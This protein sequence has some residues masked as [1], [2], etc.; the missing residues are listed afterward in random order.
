MDARS[1]ISGLPVF[2]VRRVLELALVPGRLDSV[3]LSAAQR[4][5][6]VL[7]DII[8][9]HVKPKK[10][11]TEKN[12]KTKQKKKQRRQKTKPEILSSRLFSIWLF[13]FYD[14]RPFHFG[15]RTLLSRRPKMTVFFSIGPVLRVARNGTL[16]VLKFSKRKEKKREKTGL[17]HG[18]M[19]RH[20][21]SNQCFELR[22]VSRLTSHGP[23]PHRRHLPSTTATRSTIRKRRHLQT[24]Q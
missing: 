2:L 20:R 18:G 16:T 6:N 24:H 22:L 8:S 17:A 19:S 13:F 3:L 9:G 15:R 21:K 10:K 14:K 12:L 11:T 23:R 1:I 7:S 4:P 5:L